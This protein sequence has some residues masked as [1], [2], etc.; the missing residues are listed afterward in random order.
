[1][2]S[3]TLNTRFFLLQAILILMDC[4]TVAYISPILVSLGYTNLQIGQIMTLGALAS[5]L[6]R[7]LWGVLNDRFSCAKQVTLAGTLVG[8]AGYY[9]LTC[10][11]GSV[12][13]SSVAVMG[14]YVTVVCMMNFV[15]SWALRL[16]GAGLPLNYGATRAGGS[17]SYAFGAMLF[18][19][20]VA[21]WGFRPGN[22]ILWVLWVLLAVVVLSLPNPPAPKLSPRRITLRRGL[23]A[24]SGNR[25]YWIMLAAFFLSTLASS[26][27]ESF[28]SVRILS[29]GGTEQHVGFALFLQ[30]ISELPAMIGYT[31]LRRRIRLSPAALMGVAMFCYGLKALTLGTVSSLALVMAAALFQALSFA[32]FTPACVDFMLETVPGEYLATAH[33]LFLAAGQGAGAVVGNSMSGALAQHLGMPAMFQTV[34]LLAFLASVLAWYCAKNTNRRKVP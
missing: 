13:E 27:M 3:R 30:A 21:R 1:M 6:A 31:R 8:L 2:S 9:L 20:V 32:L 7:P 28:Y 24:L 33:L 15:D 14:L 4:I 26:S 11:G 18:G 10:G 19:L 12:W 34:S 29:L 17:L 5:T 25:I 23:A 22:W 16:I